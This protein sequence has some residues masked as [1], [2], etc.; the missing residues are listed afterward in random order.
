[1]LIVLLAVL[2]VLAYPG[3]LA[4]PVD[5]GVLAYPGFLVFHADLD[6]LADLG[7]LVGPGYLAYPAVPEFLAGLG[8][9]AFLAALGFLVFL[10]FLDCLVFPEVPD[11]LVFP[12]VPS[13]CNRWTSNR[14]RVARVR[15]CR[16][17]ARNRRSASCMRPAV[18]AREAWRH[19]R[20]RCCSLARDPCVGNS[21]WSRSAGS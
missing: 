8:C 19:Q 17:R 9:L 11:C 3:C 16:P 7:F 15:P 5:L 6:F 18:W 14:S 21:M 10:E 12:E 4:F 13:D 1:M 20:N 2:G